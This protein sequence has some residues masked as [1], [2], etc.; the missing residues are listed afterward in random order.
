MFKA[1]GSTLPIAIPVL[2]PK[3]PSLKL[4]AP[5][6]RRI[7]ASRWYSNYG[8]LV[9]EFEQRI[10]SK[11]QARREWFVSAAS[12]TAAIVGAIL[13]SAG[14]AKPDRP[15]AIVPAFT[16]VAT[17]S[18]VEQCGFRPYLCDVDESSWA[19]DPEKVLRHSH[20]ERVGVVVPVA[21]F[22]RPLAQDGWQS[23]QAKTGIPVVIDG[24]AC[25]DVLNAS[26]LGAIPVALSFHATKCFATAEGG[27]VVVTE[28]GLAERVGQVLNF[29]FSGERNSRCANINGKLSEY[30]AA[31]GLAML[32]EWS[33]RRTAFDVV[34]AAYRD[35][36]NQHG[37]AQMVFTS[38]E[39][40][41]SY[42]LFLADDAEQSRR[43]QESLSAGGVDFRQWY[44]GG[45]HC[46]EY[47]SDAP[48][49]ALTIT[50]QL[51]PRLLGIPVAPDLAL[52]SISRIVSLI[53][54]AVGRR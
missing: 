39:I 8:P 40:S 51:A 23:F 35:A 50:E 37:L 13:A 29:G 18:A 1:T 12:G 10:S 45:L 28:R 38:P 7:D 16:F 20:L 48:R 3:L 31:I 4:L 15:Y 25:F 9:Q 11:L 17:A 36:A 5:Y 52:D 27:A 22:G 26:A 53:A 41:R 43:V 24:A 6:L 54:Q 42:V 19:L 34:A 46:H 2:R 49:E 14:R 44:G 32:D 21:P 47:L 30:H 33:E